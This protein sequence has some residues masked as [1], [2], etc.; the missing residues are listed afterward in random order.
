MKQDQF[1]REEFLRR[2]RIY[3][4][5]IGKEKHCYRMAAKWEH[6]LYGEINDIPHFWINIDQLLNRIMKAILNHNLAKEMKWVTNK[7]SFI[8]AAIREERKHLQKSLREKPIEVKEAIHHRTPTDE[9]MIKD[10]NYW[11]T[12]F[13]LRK[14][15]Y[16][17]FLNV[18]NWSWNLLK[19]IEVE[20]NR[21]PR[22]VI[23]KNQH[24]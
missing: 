13:E 11:N 2:V 7:I 4:K 20:L 23:P 10:Q 16:T 14:K 15:S 21:V 18:L 6:E 3:G 12:L 9:I 24:I 5:A 8:K 19:E 1:L 17:I 22:S